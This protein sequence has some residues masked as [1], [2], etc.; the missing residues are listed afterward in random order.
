ME[1]LIG[2]V[3]GVLEF[4]GSV[5]EGLGDW[6]GA[7]IDLATDVAEFGDGRGRDEDGETSR[8]VTAG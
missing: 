8:R 2:G 6:L 7:L 3:L 1:E 4:V 5:L